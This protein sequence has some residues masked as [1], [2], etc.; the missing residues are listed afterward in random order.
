MKAGARFLIFDAEAQPKVTSTYVE[1][2]QQ[3]NSISSKPSPITPSTPSTGG[4]KF[5]ANCG[6]PRTSGR[7]Y[8]NSFSHFF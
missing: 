2:Y 8:S 3:V 1:S 7:Y 6:T 4:G 5:C